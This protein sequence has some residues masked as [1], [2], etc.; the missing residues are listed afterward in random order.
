MRASFLE[1]GKRCS[2][3]THDAHHG[4]QTPPWFEEYAKATDDRFRALHD[5]LGCSQ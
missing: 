1:R 3:D 4:R 2:T 5:R